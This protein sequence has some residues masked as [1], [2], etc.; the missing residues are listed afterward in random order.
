MITKAVAIGV[1]VQERFL[2]ANLFNFYFLGNRDALRFLLLIYFKRTSLHAEIGHRTR[3]L[4]YSPLERSP[5]LKF[6]S[7]HQ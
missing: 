7:L 2:L 5:Y 3:A 6:L 1:L 4:P